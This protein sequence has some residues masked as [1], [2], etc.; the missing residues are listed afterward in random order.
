MVALSFTDADGVHCVHR[1][2][3]GFRD[4]AVGLHPG[5]R[6][7][8]GLYRSIDHMLAYSPTIGEG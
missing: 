4:P 7:P 8:Q 3:C 6:V 5:M 2:V 1:Y